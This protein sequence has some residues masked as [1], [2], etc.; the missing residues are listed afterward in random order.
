MI[1]ILSGLFIATVIDVRKRRI[2]NW[3]T[4]IMSISGLINSFTVKGWSG[5]GEHTLAMLTGLILFF[6]FYLMGVFGAGDAKLMADLGAVMGFPFIFIASAVIILIGGIISLLVLLKSKGLQHVMFLIY[7]FF[8][9]LFTG[10]IKEFNNGITKTS[11]NTF[12]FSIAI[13]IGS[14]ITLWHIYPNV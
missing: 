13:T 5:L 9:A 11:E 6:I 1:I 12:P 8:K 7:S 2:P 10:T 3:L 4:V 14:L